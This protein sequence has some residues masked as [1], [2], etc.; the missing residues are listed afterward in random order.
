[1][2]LYAEIVT[3][4]VCELWRWVVSG[5]SAIVPRSIIGV[6]MAHDGTPAPN[7]VRPADFSL[8][9]SGN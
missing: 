6:W 7:I 8:L 5:L 3:V 4:S 2:K 9:P 1:M